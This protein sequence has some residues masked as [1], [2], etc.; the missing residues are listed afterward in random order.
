MQ[1]EN[2]EE[3]TLSVHKYVAFDIR[4]TPNRPTCQQEKRRWSW[5]KFKQEKL[6]SFVE[7]ISMGEVARGKPGALKLGN[8]TTEACN[9]SMPKGTY[10][11]GKKSTPWWL[12]DIEEMRKLQLQFSVEKRKAE[13]RTRT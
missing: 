7:T 13:K 4:F 12:V 3:Y 11:G 6:Q 10:K 2:L 1:L 8:I 5:R 9:Q